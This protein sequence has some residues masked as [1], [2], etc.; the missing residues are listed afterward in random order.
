M[1]KGSAATIGAIAVFCAVLGLSAWG[2]T[3]TSMGADIADT[4][5]I[6][7][8]SEL[9][10]SVSEED[11]EALQVVQKARTVGLAT[12]RVPDLATTEQA[13]VADLEEHLGTVRAWH[14]EVDFTG[15]T[16]QELQA[17]ID[18]SSD[19][20]IRIKS[21]ALVLD[22]TIWLRNDVH[23]DGNGSRIDCDLDGPAFRI[24]GVANATVEHVNLVGN[25]SIGIL[26]HN[27]SLVQIVG[28]NFRDLNGK[29]VFVGG[30]STYFR[31]AE[32]TFLRCAQGA[33][34]AAGDASYGLIEANQA[35]NNFGYSNWMAGIVLTNLTSDDP[36]DIWQAFPTD[37]PHFAARDT[38]ANVPTSAH[39]MVVR[40]N[41]VQG[42]QSSGIYCDG[43]YGCFVFDNYVAGN[44]KEGMCLDYGALS[45]Y[46]HD[47]EFADNGKRIRQS[48]EALELDG[49][50]GYGKL[51]D[52]SAAAKLPGVSLD[53]A[54][55]NVIWANNVH[56]NWGG[57]VKAVCCAVRN[58][59]VANTISNNNR[60]QNDVF[61]F[62]GIELGNAEGP[63]AFDM[64]HA[65]CFQNV[66]VGN[67]ITGN[68]YA[69]AFISHD[70]TG[71]LVTRNTIEDTKRFSIMVGSKLAN[72]IAGNSYTGFVLDRSTV[73]F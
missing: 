68:H 26:V 16:A 72:D 40:G 37:P 48:D 1:R 34:T 73:P 22:Q 11:I 29:A 36:A 64:D 39:S 19:V 28:C 41:Q 23:I 7:A 49:M 32:C 60:G 33:I 5:D 24:E 65:A 47:N 14:T 35:S 4:F 54:A 53:N 2:A 31:V 69:G 3:Q 17:C 43:V 30:S 6:P 71:N 27:S 56:D 62:T 45:C 57:G 20:L 9:V 21:N 55:Y 15:T 44:D 8:F 46:V 51:S 58:T 50:L 42:N 12:M 61:Y 66:V 38:L 70:S 63:D 25:A 18:S 52:G 67:A 13:L 10:T 59:I